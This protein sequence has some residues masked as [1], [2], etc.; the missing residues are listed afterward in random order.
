MGKH[1][2]Q[3]DSLKVTVIIWLHPGCGHCQYQLNVIDKNIHRFGNVRFFLLSGDR[4]YLNKN[5]CISW[6]NLVK[7]R[8]VFFGFVDESKFIKEFGS[9]VTPSLL[10]FNRFGYLEKKIQGETHLNKI[11]KIIEN[12]KV[13]EHTKSGYN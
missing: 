1:S 6:P 9:M 10:I 13:P 3:N 8:N 5:Y 11:L 7:S 4:E 2:I 12:L